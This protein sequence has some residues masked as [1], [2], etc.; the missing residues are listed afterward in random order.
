MLAEEGMD[1]HVHGIF[2]FLIRFII[3]K[4]TK[5]IHRGE[6]TEIILGSSATLML[7]LW[8]DAKISQDWKAKAAWL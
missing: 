1:W 2:Y 8:N 4:Y 5:L 6:T 3:E 7:K